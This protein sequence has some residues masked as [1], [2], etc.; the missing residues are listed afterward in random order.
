MR[1]LVGASS[2]GVSAGAD[3]VIASIDGALER[4]GSDLRAERAGCIG[5]CFAEVLVEIRDA[6]ESRF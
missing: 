2:C 6:G 1:I 3:A 4:L 5:M